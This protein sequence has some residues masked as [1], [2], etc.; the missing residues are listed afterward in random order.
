L[1][2]RIGASQA[3]IFFKFFQ[4]FSRTTWRFF[5]DS[6][7]LCTR[8]LR[9]LPYR[10][11]Q[12]ASSGQNSPISRSSCLRC[13]VP[14]SP[15]RTRHRTHRAKRNRRHRRL[16]GGRLTPP[17][18]PFGR[19]DRSLA[20]GA[21]GGSIASVGSLPRG[22]AVLLPIFVTSLLVTIINRIRFAAAETKKPLAGSR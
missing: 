22:A 14:N 5:D 8:L 20:L 18:C 19:A 7:R 16:Y 3:A 9:P 17:R 12:S 11:S 21:V 10:P 1:R 15:G 6:H 4:S 2:I 13:A